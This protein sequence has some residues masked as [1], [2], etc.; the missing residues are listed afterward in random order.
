VC[1]PGAEGVE[2]P[3]EVDI[4]HALPLVCLKLLKRLAFGNSCIGDDNVHASVRAGSLAEGVTQ[5]LAVG[6]VGHGS[7]DAVM[8]CTRRLECG[9]IAPGDGDLAPCIS[10]RVRNRTANAA[11]A[12]GHQCMFSG[13]VGHTLNSCSCCAARCARRKAWSPPAR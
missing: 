5:R 4:D 13:Q 11:A 1:K 9:F 12:A 6:H 3:G 10:Q 7:T 2:H 8:T